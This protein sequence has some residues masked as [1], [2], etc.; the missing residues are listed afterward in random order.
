MMRL[1]LS[2]LALALA[3]HAAPARAQMDSRDAIELRNQIL[4]L[5]RDV[6]GL[7]EQIARGGG[8]ALGSAR[9]PP[10]VVTAAPTNDITAALLERVSQLEEK[11]RQLQGRADEEAN[12]R[13][14]QD[15]VLQKNIDDLDFKL[16]NGKTPAPA[17][18]P[19][20]PSANAG[21]PAAPVRRTPE[22]AMQ[23]GNAAL[24]RRDYA[25]AEAAAKEVLAT[26]KS[27]RA[28]DAQFL[29]A[30]SLAGKKD[31]AG[32]AVAY[33]DTY[34]RARSG[35]H[36]ADSLLGEANALTALGE[37]KAACV[38]LEKMRAEFPTLRAD[39]REGV[40]AARSRAGCR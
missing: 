8:S 30:Q 32:A 26:P 24:A 18:P 9:T 34:S 15:D 38:A 2:I 21:Q 35:T 37:K 3:L 23:E 4:D 36:A 29:L 10:P 25:A 33:D 11:V 1:L 20:A 22:L 39:Q 27:P 5:K 16:S 12:T 31:Y 19:R 6:Q 40:A 17:A 28:T 14:T 13:K 7:R